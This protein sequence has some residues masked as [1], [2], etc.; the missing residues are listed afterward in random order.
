MT[1][2]VVVRERPPEVQLSTVRGFPDQCWISITVD[3]LYLLNMLDKRI[4]DIFVLVGNFPSGNK[5][6]KQ[7]ERYKI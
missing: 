4:I 5:G 7:F 2:L 3:Y 1:G 6:Y